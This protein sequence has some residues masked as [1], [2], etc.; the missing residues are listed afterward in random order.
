MDCAKFTCNIC[1]AESP[2]P[3]GQLERETPTC[4]G[5]GSGVRLRALVALLSQELF[6]LQMTLPE[7]PVLKSIRAIGMTD[8]PA[9]AGGLAE[10][11]DYTNTFYHQAPRL[12][13]T[14]PDE[15]DFGRYDFILSSEVLEHVSAPVERAFTSLYRLL[16][17]D[18]L[19][20]FTTPY[21]LGNPIIEHF[22]DLHEYTIANLAGR[23]VLVNRRRDGSIEVFEDLVF[24]DGDG[25]TLE[26]R[27]FRQ[28]SLVEILR[29]AGFASV[30]FAAENRP[31]WGVEHAQSWSLPIIARK[32]KFS[33]SARELA[34]GYI[35]ASR[36]AT[37]SE[38]EAASIRSDYEHFTAYHDQRE[39]ELARDHERLVAYHNEREAELARELAERAEW[40]RRVEAERD[41]CL[42]K[43]E[44]ELE[45]T[46]TG[47]NRLRNEFWTR[48]GRKLGL[49]RYSK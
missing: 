48:V 29:D 46:R 37:L 19:L 9:L 43:F 15:R 3:P 7:F 49:L 35:A 44:Q 13:L 40:V 24:H 27:K 39:A 17:P 31:E 32:G 30:H 45:Q 14:Q 2:R 10:K 28:G 5:C 23:A 26:M 42:L 21:G 1:G 25:S 18:G 38:N 20:L 4:A 33:I 12:D 47:L 34:A 16:K 22:P 36:R 11:F 41:V 8:P 6:G